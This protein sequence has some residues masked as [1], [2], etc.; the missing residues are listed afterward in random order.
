MN[1]TRDSMKTLRVAA[2]LAFLGAATA[3]HAVPAIVH[4][5]GGPLGGG[6]ANA[7]QISS[8]VTAN[9]FTLAV[10]KT[11]TAFTFWASVDTNQTIAANFV[12]TIGWAIFDDAGTKP[13]NLL[14]SG[15]D[16]T[17]AITATGLFN[18][19]GGEIVKMDADFIG[20]V[21][22]AAGNYWLALHEGNWGSTFDASE[23]FWQRTTN[24]FA[25]PIVIDINET[26][27]T[28]WNLTSNFD[29][30]FVLFEEVREDPENPNEPGNGAIPEPAS[31][32][33]GAIGF[34]ALVRRQRRQEV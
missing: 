20:G 10:Q 7:H 34:A 1:M 30:A 2:M 19:A 32:M 25:D 13:G 15:Q 22:L 33:M 21:T 17:I 5:N 28:N 11:L 12:G 24:I 16:S 29:G 18:L 14:F 3:A 31:A 8:A 26:N 6:S 9:D 23:I 4:D 27:P